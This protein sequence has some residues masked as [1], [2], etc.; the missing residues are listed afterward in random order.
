MNITSLI[1]IF[2]T[3]A[4]VH[5]S[6]Y[7]FQ[8][9]CSTSA[10]SRRSGID[11][12]SV[13]IDRVCAGEIKAKLDGICE[14]SS[15]GNCMAGVVQGLATNACTTNSINCFLTATA[16]DCMQ[17]YD[18]KSIKVQGRE[19]RLCTIGV[20]ALNK[21]SIPCSAQ[22]SGEECLS[23]W[24]TKFEGQGCDVAD[25][26]CQDTISLEGGHG[27]DIARE[28]VTAR[29]CTLQTARCAGPDTRN[30][31][32]CSWGRIPKNL[33]DKFVACIPSERP[34]GSVKPETPQGVQ[35]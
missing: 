30:S 11:D 26:T 17:P 23:Y 10:Q 2:I 18:V 33:T 14:V 21:V 20:K 4:A 25:E 5:A 3:T 32:K 8:F 24:K 6:A 12:G 1:V 34:R 35:K 9:P 7:D 31:N 13:G 19:I 29:D 15:V 27:E 16:T 28:V 22:G